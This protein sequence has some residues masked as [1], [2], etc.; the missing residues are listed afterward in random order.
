MGKHSVVAQAQ[1]FVGTPAF[2]A[3]ATATVAGSLFGIGSTVAMAAPQAHDS[4]VQAPKAVAATVDLAADLADAKAVAEAAADDS[5]ASSGWTFN[6]ATVEIKEESRAEDSRTASTGSAESSSSSFTYQPVPDNGELGGR[7]A[8]IASQ[9]VGRPYVWGGTSPAGW[10]CS[11]FVG[12]VYAQAGISLPR[13]TE[14]ILSV[15]TPVSASQ[16]QPG[17]V[18]YWPG[19]VGIYMGDGMHVAAQT[20]ALGT[21]YSPVYGSPTYLRFG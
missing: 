10:D 6:T 4:D 19:H 12:W 7:I 14:A 2:K 5:Q 3:V 20:P 17:D 1:G 15:G 16:A 9:G 8:A 13:T 11:G 18:M 21:R